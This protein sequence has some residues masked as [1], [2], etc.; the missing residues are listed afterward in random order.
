MIGTYTVFRREFASYFTSPLASLFILIFL[1]LSGVF[2]FFLGGLYARGQADLVS[3][4]NFHPWLYLFLVPSLTMRLWAEERKSGT[5]ELL[6]TLPLSIASAVCGKF[7]AAW[8]LTGLA[9]LLTAPLWL[10]VN[11]LGDPDNGVI[12]AS[13]LGSWLMAGAFIA[14]GG[15]LSA[16]TN[17]QIIAF[18]LS[19]VACFVLVA[20]GSPLVLDA[21]ATWAPTALLDSVAAISVLAHFEAISRGVLDLRDLGYFLILITTFL[22]ATGIAVSGQ[23]DA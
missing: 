21:F 4:F 8:L 18:I 12:T 11:Y 3:F 19:A 16:L 1:V 6:L 9:L 20:A 14:V 10:T 2:S 5:V 17:N 22:L 13:Y 7:L 15:F 23:R